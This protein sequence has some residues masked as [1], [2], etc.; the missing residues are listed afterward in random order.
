M[1]KRLLLLALV[2]GLVFCIGNTS[3]A[4]DDGQSHQSHLSVAGPRTNGS[5]RAPG[6]LTTLFASNNGYAGNMVDFTPARDLIFTGIDVNCD[7]AGAAVTANVYWRDGTSVGF[8]NSSTGW[9][10]LDSGTGVSAGT[11]QHTYIDLPNAASQTFLAGQV[12]GIYVALDYPTVRCEYT[13]G[14]PKVYS[15]ADLSITTNCGKGIGFSG[16][17]FY[18]RQWNGTIYYDDAG[19]VPPRVD[20]KCNGEDSGVQIYEGD[21][22][23]IDFNVWAGIGAGYPVDVWVALKTPFGFFTYDGLGPYFGW[24]FGL[25]NAY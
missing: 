8:E 4:T 23:K 16:S 12:Y 7:P 14:G 10:L 11:D 9:N 24:N 20:I 13:N 18:P 6:S 2:V 5:T 3:F 25:N 17:T 1:T 15:N 22:A 19:P 21:N